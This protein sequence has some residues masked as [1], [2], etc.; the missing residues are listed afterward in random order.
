M[1]K[2][3]QDRQSIYDVTVQEFGQIDNLFEVIEDNNLGYNDILA[4]GME[5]EINNTDKGIENVKNEFELK[6]KKLVNE[7]ILL[8]E[9]VCSNLVVPTIQAAAVNTITIDLTNNSSYNLTGVAILN[10]T[11]LDSVSQSVYIESGD[12]QTATFNISI[13]SNFYGYK[14]LTI[15]GDCNALQNILIQP[16]FSI[17]TDQDGAG[18]KTVNYKLTFSGSGNVEWGDSTSST[19]TTGID[20]TK[21]YSLVGAA[22]YTII[23]TVANQNITGVDIDNANLTGTFDASTLT[24]LSQTLDI[25]DNPLLTSFIQPGSIVNINALRLDNCGWTSLNLTNIDFTG[26]LAVLL[27]NNNTSLTNISFKST[28][29]NLGFLYGYSCTNLATLDISGFTGNLGQVR[30]YDLTSLTTFTAPTSSGTTSEFWIYNSGL[31]ILN[32]SGMSGLG[33]DFDCKNSSSLTTL[34]T[35]TTSQAIRID[36]SNCSLTS[37]D[38]SGM[39]NIVTEILLNDNNLTSATFPASSGT[40]GTFRIQNNSLSSL[41]I[42]G[43]TLGLVIRGD[44]NTSLSSLTL[45]TVSATCGFFVFNNCAL[46]VIDWTKFTGANNGID[47]RLQDNSMTVAE[48][49]E[50]L[51]KIDTTGWINGTLDIDG[52][53]AAPD[54]SSGGFDGT[55]AKANLITKGWSVTTS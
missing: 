31:T 15:T 1:R 24:S 19:L 34:N 46:G 9:I 8:G 48:V 4:G 5:L 44:G 12:T 26:A 32:I 3:V 40:I 54:G 33:G 20:A 47:I 21:D 2:L 37:I 51:V 53:N 17:R 45:P 29:S 50:N 52:T 36:A 55:T 27:F 10:I 16:L 18:F 14:I 41:D 6:D 7:Q 22:I 30:L 13:P 43:L 42:S 35:P 11:G 38:F 23:S 28:S 49:N 39:T 25:G